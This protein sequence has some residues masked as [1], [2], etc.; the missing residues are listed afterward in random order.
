MKKQKSII[1]IGYGAIGRRHH[2]LLKKYKNI[3]QIYII[4]KHIKK[5]NFVIQNLNY[6]KNL[7][8]HYI[9][10]SSKTND[11]Y[12]NLYFI[13]KNFKN[14]II[15]IEKPLFNK[16]K[17]LK[18][19]KNKVFIGYN[20][21]FHPVINY[22]KNFI[23]NKKLYNLNVKCHSY[24]P[25]WRKNIAYS[26]SNSAKKKYG[27]GVL[28]ELSHELDYINWLFAGI[29]KI[30]YVSLN[31]YS[32]LKIETE[33]SVQVQGCTKLLDF[34]LDL[35]FYSF[36]DERTIELNG[37]GFTLRGDLIKNIIEIFKNK[38]IK[39]VKF[40]VDKNF[41]YN[42]QHKNILEKKF[43][44]VCKYK[45]GLKLMKLIDKI[46]RFKNEK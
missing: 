31:K 25:N 30:K 45:D 19:K 10:V 20:L 4:S 40:G 22:I 11:H 41:T 2:A 24:L 12:K 29:K 8:P 5:K 34:N 21:R 9:V 16:F 38:K 43:K 13:E 18:I 27:G 28:L 44:N 14:K 3:Y 42:L 17:F 36:K 15:L 23:K 1:I 32:K 37:E 46:R 39:K 35:N 26:E 6:I 33:D 7:N